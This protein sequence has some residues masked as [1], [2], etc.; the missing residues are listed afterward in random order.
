MK[1]GGLGESLLFLPSHL[2]KP[3]LN[4][5]SDLLRLPQYPVL[6]VR[7]AALRGAARGR[8]IHAGAGR[9]QGRGRRYMR[10]TQIGEYCF[11]KTAFSEEGRAWAAIPTA[12]ADGP[13]FGALGRAEARQRPPTAACGKRRCGGPRP[14]R[15]HALLR[16]PLPESADNGPVP[17]TAGLSRPGRPSHRAHRSAPPPH[18]PGVTPHKE[19]V[20]NPK[21]S[22][23]PHSRARSGSVHIQKACSFEPNL[24]ALPSGGRFSLPYNINTAPFNGHLSEQLLPSRMRTYVCKLRVY[25]CGYINVYRYA[26]SYLNEGGFGDGRHQSRN[27]KSD[28]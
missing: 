1:D 7:A 15:T 2:C 16:R 23:Q 27:H 5:L 26:R 25:T 11:F 13:G 8:T 6:G 9:G 12:R 10:R 4:G 14:S 19:V 17:Q 3:V 21:G 20:G 28:T 24:K 18:V 22:P